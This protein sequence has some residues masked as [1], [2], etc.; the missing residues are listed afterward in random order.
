MAGTR[1]TR[2]TGL[3]QRHRATRVREGLPWVRTLLRDLWETSALGAPP[4]EDEDSS[5]V[6]RL[7]RVALWK[8]R[9]AIKSVRARAKL[10]LADYL[11]ISPKNLSGF[12]FDTDQQAIRRVI[13]WPRERAN[14]KIASTGLAPR[15]GHPSTTLTRCEGHPVR[16]DMNCPLCASVHVEAFLVRD[17]VPVH[18]NRLFESAEAA[19]DSARGQLRMSVCVVCG[20][21]STP[22]STP[23]GSPTD[24]ATTTTRTSRPISTDTSNLRSPN[25]RRMSASTER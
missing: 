15:K 25:W 21:A 22:R 1:R 16:D 23:P 9:L 20:F 13:D 17:D 4:D 10:L 8:L 5:G 19:T 6:P 14:I 18:Q 11:N 12:E 24:A 2:S 3:P 7:A